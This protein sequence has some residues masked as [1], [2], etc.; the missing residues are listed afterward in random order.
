MKIL[1]LSSKVPFP[2]KDGGSIATLGLANG[3]AGNNNDIT[4][5]CLNT[6]KHFVKNED[7]PERLTSKMRIITVSHNTEIRVIKALYNL[8]FSGEPYNGIRFISPLFEAGLIRLLKSE[9]F[10]FIQLEGPYMG[11]Y[12]PVIKKYSDAKISLRAHNVEHEIWARK[13]KNERNPFRRWYLKLLADR[14]ERHET[15]VLRT[16]DLLIPISERD[17]QLLL[18][19][20][21]SLRSI[22]IPAGVDAENYPDPKD[23]EYPSLFF[24]GSLD[25]MPN[26]EGLEWFVDNVWPEVQKDSAIRFHVGGRNAPAWLEKKLLS[27]NIIFHGEIENAYDFMNHYAIMVSPVFSGS[28]IRIKILEAMMMGKAVISTRIG[29]E[30]ISYTHGENIMLADDPSTFARFIRDYSSNRKKYDKVA[31]SGRQ[32]VM[33]SFNNLAFCKTLDEFYRNNLK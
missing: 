9:E 3:L 5:L 8:I 12:I 32:F 1:I 15:K 10:D 7:L 23:P 25:W 20:E 2:P 4:L 18:K 27:N 26:Q 28:G 33:E 24:I 6:S 30:G 11:Y 17:Q 16:I 31:S 21:P 13:S 19:L 22:V 29:S 14:I